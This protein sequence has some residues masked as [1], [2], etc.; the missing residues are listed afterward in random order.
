MTG[1]LR[2]QA[3]T[4]T[5]QIQIGVSFLLSSTNHSERNQLKKRKY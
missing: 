1:T 4:E 3:G 2:T 5:A